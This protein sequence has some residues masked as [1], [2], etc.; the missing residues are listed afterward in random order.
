MTTLCRYHKIILTHKRKSSWNSFF[1][2]YANHW[3]QSWYLYTND[4]DFH[5]WR[6]HLWRFSFI[7]LTSIRSNDGNVKSPSLWRQVSISPTFYVQLFSYE[8]VIW[9]FYLL[10]VWVCSFLAKE[11]WLK[12]CSLYVGEIDDRSRRLLLSSQCSEIVGF[13]N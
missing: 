12:S 4:E 5:F 3:N 6:F 2:Y 10:T 9:S 11:N 7:V 8:S 1:L 13:W